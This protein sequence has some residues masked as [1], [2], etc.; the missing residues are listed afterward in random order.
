MNGAQTKGS[1]TNPMKDKDAPKIWSRI[2]TLPYYDGAAA[3]ISTRSPSLPSCSGV[4][5]ARSGSVHPSSSPFFLV[6]R[7]DSQAQ[8]AERVSMLVE[9]PT[10]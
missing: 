8:A 3:P 10:Q 7:R 6:A 9:R 5:T 1:S 2:S 4:A